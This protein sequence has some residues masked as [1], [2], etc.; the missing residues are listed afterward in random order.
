MCDIKNLPFCFWA[1]DVNIPG[2]PELS[3]VYTNYFADVLSPIY[4]LQKIGFDRPILVFYD[5]VFTTQE[6]GALNMY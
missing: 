4:F 1:K 5:S 2:Y 6:N 3:V